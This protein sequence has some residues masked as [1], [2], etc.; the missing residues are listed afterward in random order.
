MTH[1]ERLIMFLKQV[2]NHE[3]NNCNSIG[4][5]GCLRGSHGEADCE[6]CAFDHNRRSL[7]PIIDILELNAD[8]LNTTELLLKNG[9]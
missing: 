7:K 8:Q 9:E 5:S 4:S 3:A 2:E 6:N 1:A